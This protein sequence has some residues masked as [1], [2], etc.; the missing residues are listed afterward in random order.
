ML[1][2]ESTVLLTDALRPP[3]GFRLDHAVV[4]TYTLNLT[5]LL[6]A[7][8]TFSLGDVDS[9]DALAAGDP[10]RLLDAVQ[11]HVEHTTVFVQTAGI[12]VPA[13][14][15][16]IHTFLED[17]IHEVLPP[18]EGHLFHPKLWAVRFADDAGALHHRVIVASRNL[19]LDNSWDTVLVL[20]EDPDGTIPAA[21]AADAVAALPTMALDPLPEARA[22]A[23]AD[24][25]RTLRAVTLAAPEPFTG[26]SLLPLGLDDDRPWPFSADPERVLAISPFVSAET[27]K[28]IRGT[29]SEAILVSRAEAMDLL[30]RRQLDGWSTRVLHRAAEEGDDD[31]SSL[32]A[33]DEFTAITD[34]PD[35]ADESGAVAVIRLDGLHAK[36]VVLDLPGGQ[37]MVVTGSANLTGQAWSG[38]M[39]MNAVLTGPTAT[40]GVHAVLGQGRESLGLD[41]ILQPYTPQHE[42]GTTDPAIATSYR[43]EQFHRE[44]ARQ[45]PELVVTEL[46]EDRVEARLSLTMPDD[47]PGQ[48]R[49]WL[50]TVPAQVRDLAPEQSWEVA[51]VN[52]TPYLAVETTAGEG[53]GRVTRRCILMMRLRG[54]TAD[55]RG[56]VLAALLSNQ[57]AV[58]RYLA[59]LLGLDPLQAESA[60][61]EDV[62][63]VTEQLDAAGDG[64]AG[65]Q[66]PP[67]VLFEPLVRA[68]GRDPQAMASVARQ[69]AEL[70]EMP[71]AQDLVAPEFLQM[72]DVVLRVAQKRGQS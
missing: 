67:I 55:R 20:D 46:D 43:L 62:M 61:L 69:V 13:S 64:G 12:H 59:L 47:G 37:S 16:R 32:R 42:A 39:E 56:A 28:S 31:Q 7:P 52:V 1:H 8:M 6:I 53:E 5:A 54:D 30:G 26:G 63:T 22:A 41:A 71:G 45:R 34:T 25:A 11:R 18:N 40:C 2:P 51:P 38:G 57:S 72:W 33:V 36:T 68:A 49:V 15:S 19:T 3:V 66:L 70:R 65:P 4:T 35:G 14:H 24:L 17:S 29:S 9:A 27:L 44:L 48:T 60:P 58:L 10:V 21:P 23:V 50:T